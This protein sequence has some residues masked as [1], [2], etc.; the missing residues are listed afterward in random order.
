MD[1]QG[2]EYGFFDIVISKA[3]YETQSYENIEIYSDTTISLN[4][5][6]D[7]FS[8]VLKL[9]NRSDNRPVKYEFVQVNEQII[10]INDQGQVFVDDLNKDTLLH[11]SIEAN[12]FFK[13]TDSTLIMHDTTILVG[14]YPKKQVPVF[15]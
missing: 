5:E 7:K 14:L 9:I 2:V 11:Y 13:L 8:T 4:I 1:M 15:M 10:P 3:G 12:D 6:Q